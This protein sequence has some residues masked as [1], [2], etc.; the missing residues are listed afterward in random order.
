LQYANL[1]VLDLANLK[2]K[3]LSEIVEPLKKLREL[4]LEYNKS[5]QFPQSLCQAIKL[6]LLDLAVNCL[7]TEAIPLEISN[8]Q[9][10]KTIHLCGTALTDIQHLDRLPTLEILTMHSPSARIQVFPTAL[11]EP[12]FSLNALQS[13]KIS[14]NSHS[15]IPDRFDE[16]PELQHV[17]LNGMRLDEIP[18]TLV[19]HP[20]LITFEIRELG[21]S[22]FSEDYNHYLKEHC[23]AYRNFRVPIEAALAEIEAFPSD[24]ACQ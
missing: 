17:T 11:P 2:L 4:D 5:P 3:T 18:E 20:Q 7:M 19:R 22:R 23:L 21:G 1:E 9:K 12:I 14:T 10:L 13:L 15:R 24:I 8:L 16:L 6:E